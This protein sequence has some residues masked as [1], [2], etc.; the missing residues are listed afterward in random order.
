[1]IVTFD[2]EYLI[3]I[4]NSIMAPIVKKTDPFYP[5]HPGEILKDEIRGL[6]ASLV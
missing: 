5:I 3:E 6:C 2:Q 1:M 4:N